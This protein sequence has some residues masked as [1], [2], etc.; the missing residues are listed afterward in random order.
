MRQTEDFQFD[1]NY[2][3]P[4]II[5]VTKDY[6][7]FKI[8]PCNRKITHITKFSRSLERSNK[9]YVHPIIVNKDLYII[10]GQH[11][12]T[13]A[14]LMLLP[15]YY[16]VDEFFVI[17]DL[18]HHNNT[19]SNWIAHDFCEF[20]A[21][22]EGDGISSDTKK[23][24]QICKNICEEF[25]MQNDL[26]LNC[27]QSLTTKQTRTKVFKEG[28][29]R[30]RHSN[31]KI[32]EISSYLAK[33]V[34]LANR[35]KLGRLNTN[36][37]H[38]VYQLYITEEFDGEKFIRKLESNIEDLSIALKFKSVEEIKSRLFAIYIKNDK[39]KYIQE[40]K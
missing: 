35:N 29:L 23:A 7:K 17:E 28:K 33:I 11:R 36:F 20:Y 15:V 26:F 38:C 32:Y 22:Y 27:F 6:E 13:Y 18:I 21:T 19:S 8:L 2:I 12:W 4:P 40:N 31:D 3:K 16:V 37:L 34:F 1:E 14:K 30:L 10:D 39:R 5:Y 9:L 25:N 24:Y